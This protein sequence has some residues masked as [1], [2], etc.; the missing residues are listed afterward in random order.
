MIRTSLALA[1][2]VSFYLALSSPVSEAQQPRKLPEIGFLDPSPPSSPYFEGFKEGLR[3]LGYVE[4]VTI[5][6]A[7]QFA[8][9]KSDRLPNLAIELVR[10]NVD[11]I[12]TV[13][14]AAT[15]AAKDATQRIPI[16]MGY[17]GD[18][19]AGS[20]VASMAHPGGNITGLSAV[21]SELSGKRLELLKAVAPKLSRVAVL[22]NPS[23]AGERLDWQETQTAARK[24]NITL[25]YIAVRTPDDFD[26]AFLKIARL[27]KTRNRV[28]GIFV[29]PD[30]LT[31]DQ[32]GRI[33]GFALSARLPTMAAWSEYAKA[34]ALMSYGPILREVYR[35]AAG[36]V[37]RII[38]GANPAELPI[39]QPTKFEFVVNLKIARTLRIK[40]P[41]SI[42]L[43]A[44]E[45]IR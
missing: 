16:V 3:E 42:L 8:D 19:V 12:V 30:A 22:S 7:P 32:R 43:Q 23:H 31:L 15:A 38:K 17:S 40:I 37:D 4:G 27:K 2:C 44:D 28:D 33:A 35:R 13:G 41:Q 36:F 18:P 11:V 34:G 20:L 25:E 6:L 14:G 29:I 10:R 45:V 1:I 21:S 5:V 9:G 24:L 26:E 39:E